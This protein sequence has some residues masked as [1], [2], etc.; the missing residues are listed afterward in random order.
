M[1]SRKEGGGGGVGVPGGQ[2]NTGT[3]VAR[4]EPPCLAPLRRG[5]PLRGAGSGRGTHTRN[6]CMSNL[7]TANGLPKK[8][9]DTRHTTSEMA[10]CTASMMKKH[11]KS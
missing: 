7:G 1:G 5:L 11:G 2:G 6:V 8:S 4:L 3:G 9:L 10:S